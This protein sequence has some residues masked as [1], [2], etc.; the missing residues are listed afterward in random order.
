M[1]QTQTE[2][3]TMG[4]DQIPARANDARFTPIPIEGVRNREGGISWWD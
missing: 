1:N 2:E 3:D 4:V